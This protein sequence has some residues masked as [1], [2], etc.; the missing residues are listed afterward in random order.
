ML[1]LA[2][3]QI[4]LGSRD[5]TWHTERHNARRARRDGEDHHASGSVDVTGSHVRDSQPSAEQLNSVLPC[6]YPHLRPANAP[7]TT[8]D[9]DTA[10]VSR[11]PVPRGSRV[12]WDKVR[13]NARKPTAIQVHSVE[14]RPRIVEMHRD[15]QEM[16]RSS[17]GSIEEDSPGSVGAFHHP[18]GNHH[19]QNPSN[20]TETTLQLQ[21]RFSSESD[22]SFEQ[23]D[24]KVELLVSNNA[25]DEVHQ[26]DL[27][28]RSSSRSSSRRFRGSTGQEDQ[29][30]N[31]H[32]LSSHTDLDGSSDSIPARHGYQR[33]RAS[34]T[35]MESEHDPTRSIAQARRTGTGSFSDR[36][37]AKQSPG[38]T[39]SLL[40]GCVDKF[41]RQSTSGLP[42]SRLCI[43]QAAPS[44]SPEKR[45][46]SSAHSS[47]EKSG[48]ETI[49]EPSR[50]LAESPRR[51][52]KYKARNEGYI[53]DE[54]A[55]ESGQVY[56]IDR[57]SIEDRVQSNPTPSSLSS[58]IESF[59]DHQQVSPEAN[60]LFSSS[61]VSRR[62]TSPYS[63][64]PRSTLRNSISTGAPP[65]GGLP[66]HPFSAT[67]RTISSNRALSPAS[68]SAFNP[69][70]SNSSASATPHRIAVYNDN[71][72]ASFQPQTPA[73]LPLNG[74]PSMSLQNPFGIGIGAAQ[75]APAGIGRRRQN[76]VRPETP[77]RGRGIEDQENLGVE[78]EARRMS[79]RESRSREWDWEFAG[80][81]EE[82]G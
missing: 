48:D 49:A 42:R 75:T 51:R 67:P 60:S 37:T 61:S 30:I 74:L 62:T 66:P 58:G 69:T 15:S 32:A 43:S 18:F 33:K 59:S 25:R 44:S 56:G 40:P 24:E 47:D 81:G 27:P 39:Q 82:E 52:K 2:P 31:S 55:L 4:T 12:F 79:V 26:F 34:T 6:S 23:D 41:R 50:L 35:G 76:S 72:P 73:R 7:I 14:R 77:T 71:L 63:F 46:R 5:L 54:A 13:A 80:E 21:S 19:S 38:S 9:S 28:I 20:Q 68:P 1:R 53:F 78:L 22:T 16:I 57:L 10:L 11:E 17:K 65:P 64:S 45:S 3:T 8:D 36:M 29:P 70:R